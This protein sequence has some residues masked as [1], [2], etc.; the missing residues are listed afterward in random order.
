[1]EH[2]WAVGRARFGSH[3]KELWAWVKARENDLWEGRV[4]EVVA[5]LRAVAAHLGSPVESLSDNE[6]ATDPRWIAYRSIG[7][8]E[9]NAARMKYPEYRA[10]NLPIGSGVVESACKHVVATRCKRAG[11]RWDQEGEEDILAL[12]CWDLSGRWDEIWKIQAA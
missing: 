3:E 4:P 8:F 10:Q 11:M 9:D 1:M 6:R 2:I 7:Y 12:R 5:A